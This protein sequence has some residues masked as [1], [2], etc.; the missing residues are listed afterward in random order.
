[1][2]N[3]NPQDT[4]SKDENVTVNNYF[5]NIR[6]HLI[7]SGK[8]QG[9]YFRKYTQEISIKNKVSG[10]VRNL[11]NGNVECILEGLPSNVEKV[12]EWCHIGPK[13][14]R[15]DKIDINYETYTGEFQGFKID[16]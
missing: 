1:M 3:K 12:I 10:W 6:A 5:S 11:K 13:N 14:S 2:S 9:V 8:V 7:I 15:V 16:G 4:L